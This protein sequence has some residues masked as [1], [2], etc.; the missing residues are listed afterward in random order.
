MIEEPILKFFK[1]SHLPPKLQE[2]SMAFYNLAI[3][4]SDELPPGEEKSMALRKLLEAKDC[5]VR[6]AL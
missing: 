3:A 5:A 2:V 6:A 4:I 1:Y